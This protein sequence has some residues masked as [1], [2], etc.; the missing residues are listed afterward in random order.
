[1]QAEDKSSK[2]NPLSAAKAAITS[3]CNQNQINLLYFRTVIIIEY[4]R[5]ITR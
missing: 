4:M 3:F 5:S 2:N 1:M